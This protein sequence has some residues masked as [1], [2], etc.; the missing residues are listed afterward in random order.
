MR[1]IGYLAY[2]AKVHCIIDI[3]FSTLNLHLF[4]ILLPISIAVPTAWT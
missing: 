1:H 2:I 4:D 3:N